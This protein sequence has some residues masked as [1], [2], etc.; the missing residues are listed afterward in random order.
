AHFHRGVGFYL[1]A[2]ERS[3]VP[4]AEHTLP[5]EGLLCKAAAE[6]S[7]ARAARPDEARPCWYLFRVWSTL[8]QAGTAARWL[9][10]ARAAAPFCALAPAEQRGLELATRAAG[11]RMPRP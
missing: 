8:G 10:R 11:P 4:G 3:K 1:L 5:P 2:V 7:L 9:E 6:L